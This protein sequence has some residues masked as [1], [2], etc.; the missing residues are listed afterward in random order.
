MA[1]GLLQWP[2]WIGVVVDDLGRARRFWGDLLGLPEAASGT[3]F[4]HFDIE[5][6]RSFEL[7]QRSEAPE[8][9]RPRFQVGFAVDDIHRVRTDLVRRGVQ[10]VTEVIEGDGSSWAYFRDPEGNVF[11]ITQ[12]LTG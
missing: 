5:G 3:D 6:G 2:S 7:I 4:V 11:E 12:R 8:Y 1:G 10:P 9:D